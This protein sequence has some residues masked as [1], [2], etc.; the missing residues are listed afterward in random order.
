MS[1]GNLPSD[2]I[3]AGTFE[4]VC[5]TVGAP[6]EVIKQLDPLAA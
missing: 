3:L 4:K 5:F 1:S 2:A 6:S